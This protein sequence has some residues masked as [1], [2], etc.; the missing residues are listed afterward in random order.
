MPSKNP[1]PLHQRP[2]S[3]VA[4]AVLSALEKAQKPLRLMEISHACGN[5]EAGCHTALVRCLLVR[6]LVRQVARGVYATREVADQMARDAR[7][8]AACTGEVKAALYHA[9]TGDLRLTMLDVMRLLPEH[10][11]QS[12]QDLR[13]RGLLPVLEERMARYIKAG[14]L[15]VKQSGASSEH[16]SERTKLLTSLSIISR[17][18]GRST[19]ADADLIQRMLERVAA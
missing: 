9:F 1:L 10:E 11:V 6:A 16:G 7:H 13:H 19:P 8:H 3:P 4:A 17:V 18:T 5:T 14:G 2:L 12:F 15:Y